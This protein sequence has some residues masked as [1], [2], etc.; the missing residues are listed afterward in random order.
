MENAK[1]NYNFII[2]SEWKAVVV[3]DRRG[4]HS[5]NVDCELETTGEK[6]L[7][8]FAKKMNL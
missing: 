3:R 7:L 2:I 1:K 6:V 5:A 4:T 8:T